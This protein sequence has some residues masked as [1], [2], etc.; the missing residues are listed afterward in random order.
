[1]KKILIIVAGSLTTVFVIIGALWIAAF[2]GAVRKDAVVSEA[3][4][5]VHASLSARYE[6]VVVFIDAIED[7]NATV[8]TYLET[9]MDART[10]F[11]DALDNN[12]NAAADDAATTLD[13]TFVTLVAYMEDN[14]ESYNTVGLYSG[15]LG[16]FSASTNKVRFDIGEYNAAVRI[17]NTHIQTFPNNL[18]VA[19]RVAL[20]EY[21]LSNYTATLPSFN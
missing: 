10:A 13:G 3:R 6:K 15:Y 21:S 17:Y 12:N 7:A 8:L 16:E 11:A 14:P 9:I 1:M 5:N 18:F 4:G 2:N 19:G 20:T